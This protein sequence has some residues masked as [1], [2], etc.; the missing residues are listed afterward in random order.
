MSRC[1]LSR[2]LS[3]H[4]A[5]FF[6]TSRSFRSICL[7]ISGA[8]LVKVSNQAAQL[9]LLLRTEKKPAIWNA[10][11]KSVNWPTLRTARWV[12][13]ELS[14][15]IMVPAPVVRLVMLGAS[16]RMPYVVVQVRYAG[17]IGK[18]YPGDLPWPLLSWQ[19]NPP[20]VAVQCH[21]GKKYQEGVSNGALQGWRVRSSHIHLCN[22]PVA[23]AISRR[24]CIQAGGMQLQGRGSSLRAHALSPTP[25]N[26][27]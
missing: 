10:G 3:S 22:L 21:E 20:L 25:S 13:Y 18:S 16:S 8:R 4:P 27:R 19:F 15:R 7:G 26:V 9:E 6:A 12:C 1:Y 17:G 24:A 23:I 2:D 14:S 5:P 11:Y